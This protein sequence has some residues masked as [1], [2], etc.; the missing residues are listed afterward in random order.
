MVEEKKL[1]RLI[2]PDGKEY[3]S[4]EK[5]QLGAIAKEKYT[6]GWIAQL[7]SAVYPEATLRFVCFSKM[8]KLPKLLATASGK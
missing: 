6:V 8:K 5:D 2:G 1:Y 3:L 7:L 4:E